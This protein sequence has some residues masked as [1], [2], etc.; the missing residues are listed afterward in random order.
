LLKR[1]AQSGR[2]SS[3][4]KNISLALNGCLDGSVFGTASKAVD[5]SVKT[6]GIRCLNR[7]CQTKDWRERVQQKL[8][9]R[10]ITKNTA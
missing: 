8:K 3:V 4:S 9:K 6:A 2:N 5:Q 7:R 10:E 1:R